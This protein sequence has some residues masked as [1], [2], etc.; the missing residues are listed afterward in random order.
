MPNAVAHVVKVSRA[1]YMVVHAYMLDVAA[2][3]SVAGAGRHAAV[4]ASRV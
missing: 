1:Y 4:R 3:A 2:A